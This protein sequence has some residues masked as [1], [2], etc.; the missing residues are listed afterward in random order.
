MAAT[1]PKRR[2]RR[3]RLAH[4][5]RLRG[6]VAVL[7]ILVL[8]IVLLA[9]SGTST[10]EKPQN[11]VN[12]IEESKAPM[13]VDTQK[14]A[15]SV[16]DLAAQLRTAILGM[17]NENAENYVQDPEKLPEEESIPTESGEESGEGEESTFD[18]D[19]DGMG[20]SAEEDVTP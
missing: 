3:Y 14:D 11:S 6:T 20:A 7:L 1:Q 9:K 18:E 17:L 16:D 10:E 2:K 15:V 13:P 4:P 12:T 8:L 5:E 19:E